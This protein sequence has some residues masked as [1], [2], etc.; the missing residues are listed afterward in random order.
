MI[1]GRRIV[2]QTRVWVP[3]AVASE[4]AGLLL[5]S[6]KP[7]GIVNKMVQDQGFNR[8]SSD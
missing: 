6:T 4:D 3:Y 7:P 5:H 2:D 1:G 8:Q